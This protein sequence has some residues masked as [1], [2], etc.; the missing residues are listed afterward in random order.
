MDH[1]D[2]SVL[3]DYVFNDD[4]EVCGQIVRSAGEP[5]KLVL[6][7]L[8]RGQI[9]GTGRALCIQDDSKR[10]FHTHPYN[11][12]AY[13]SLEDIN[14]VSKRNTIKYSLIVTIWGLWIIEK[15]ADRTINVLNDEVIDHATNR[16]GYQTKRFNRSEFQ[17]KSIDYN[18]IVRYEVGAYLDTMNRHLAGNI[19]I[20]F[21]SWKHL[22]K[23]IYLK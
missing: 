21:K 10:I 22:D 9:D 14:K 7:K 20:Y 1:I 15:I 11:A 18:D 8:T 6:H 4:M 17:S 12:Y 2:L 16:L 3:Y 19:M 23:E 13:P 5:H